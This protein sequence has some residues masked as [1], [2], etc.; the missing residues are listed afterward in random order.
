MSPGVFQNYYILR[1]AIGNNSSTIEI[2]DKYYNV[3]LEEGHKI[4]KA[5]SKTK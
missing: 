4:L 1:M 3:I 5:H 2:L